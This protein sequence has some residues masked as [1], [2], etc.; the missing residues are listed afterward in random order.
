MKKIFNKITTGLATLWIV[1]VSFFSKVLGQNRGWEEQPMYGVEYKV[2]AIKQINQP[3][4]IDTL[5]K[6]AKRPLI[7]I[8]LIVWIISFIKIKK[9]KDK[10][11][12]KKK[13]K[14]TII[15]IGILVVLIVSS[16]LLPLLLKK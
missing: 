9:T 2:W 16:L 5:I 11:Q 10:T 13:I 6:I 14:R 8:T 1:I 15:I 12:K 3:T 7:G 4:L